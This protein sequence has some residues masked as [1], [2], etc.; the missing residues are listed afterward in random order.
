MMWKA[1]RMHVFSTIVHALKDDPKTTPNGLIFNIKVVGNCNL[2]LIATKFF[3]IGVL[4]RPSC[5][6]VYRVQNSIEISESW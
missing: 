5:P 3:Q 4:M 6:D 2:M 1:K